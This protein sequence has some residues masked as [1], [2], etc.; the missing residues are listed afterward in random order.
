[1]NTICAAVLWSLW[2]FH[3]D[4]IF[5]HRVWLDLKQICVW[6]FVLSASGRSCSG[7]RCRRRSTGSAIT[8]LAIPGSQSSCPGNEQSSCSGVFLVILPKTPDI[9]M[10]HAE[11]ISRLIFARRL[12]SWTASWVP[13][14]QRGLE[15]SRIA[16]SFA[17]SCLVL[18]F[19]QLFLRI[20]LEAFVFS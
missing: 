14:H 7:R 11:A 8:C 13:T 15:C 18:L 20:R 4:M 12:R 3:N 1:M 2:T 9:H 10:Q 5:N 6:F 17:K 19:P 16:W